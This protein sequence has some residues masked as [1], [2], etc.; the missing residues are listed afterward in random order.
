MYIDACVNQLSTH[1][2]ALRQAQAARLSGVYALL[3]ADGA[4]AST[5][6]FESVCAEIATAVHTSPR[7]AARLAGDADTICPRTAL[8][9]A[10]H[11]G[12]LDT[13]RAKLIA[14]LLDSADH[15]TR[16]EA[17][18]V[19]Y[20]ATH[21][22]HEL[23]RWLLARTN[24]SSAK[25][26]KTALERRYIDVTPDADGMA[27]L[28]AYVPLELA[29]RL[30]SAVDSIARRKREPD[31]DRT[32]DQRRADALAELVDAKTDLHVTATVVLPAGSSTVGLLN[33]TPLP[34]QAAATLTSQAHTTWQLA[35]TT[36]GGV[37]VSVSTGYRPPSGMA[38][39]V[40]LRDQHC[41]FPGC[42]VPAARCDLDHLDPWPTGATSPDN[43]HCLCRTHH[44]LKHTTDWQVTTNGAAEL[45]WTSPTGRTYTTQPP[46]LLNPAA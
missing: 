23:R 25:A 45:T 27:H 2:R 3:H 31:D 38:A 1:E 26:R 6:A 5:I 16:F 34:W 20:G 35:A 28:H 30:F 19:A 41:R 22:V 14:T 44:R 33:G 10:M 24:T 9:E 21:T 46:D 15:Q 42:S 4:P 13:V 32:M 11:R 8:L 17:R 40:R 29:D 43:L 37:P 39:A 7:A 18:A 12:E 36:N